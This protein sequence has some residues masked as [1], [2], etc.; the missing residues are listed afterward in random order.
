MVRSKQR[1]S[2]GVR[3]AQYVVVLS[4]LL[5][6]SLCTSEAAQWEQIE[7]AA[8]QEGKVVVLGPPG[9]ESRDALTRGFQKMYPEITMD[10]KVTP[11][12]RLLP[13]LSLE[14]KAG[15]YLRDIVISGAS[16][17]ISTLVRNDILDPIRPSLV[18][19]DIQEPKWMGGKFDFADNAG[20]YVLTVVYNASMSIGYNSTMFSPGDLKSW[21]DLLD[22]KWKGKIAMYDPRIPGPGES[23]AMFFYVSPDLGKDYIERLFAHG[24]VLTRNPRQLW[25]W[26]AHGKYPISIAAFSAMGA[27]LK[28]QGVKIELLDSHKLKEGAYIT[29]A[30][31]NVG[32]VNKAPHPNALKVYLNYLLSRKGQLELSR[33]VGYV[34]RRLDVPRD[35]LP[36]GVVPREDS[37]FPATYKEPFLNVRAESNAY[38]RALLKGVKAQGRRGRGKRGR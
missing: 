37:K 7:A 10:Y 27:R 22:P 2:Q 11:G 35:H 38:I 23:I 28:R 1:F 16:A 31:G 26:V 12:G 29:P 14:R 5:G 3:L 20:K 9:S 25:D 33:T 30:F 8:K 18:G 17:M 32:V 4:L 36:K 19:P 13:M 6:I 24:I 34:S 21:K 15:K